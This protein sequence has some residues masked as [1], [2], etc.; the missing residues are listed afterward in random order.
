MTLPGTELK[1]Y[2]HQ[3]W[4]FS[5]SATLETKMMCDFKVVLSFF[6]FFPSQIYF[7]F[8]YSF[9]RV[10]FALC[11]FG[12][13]FLSNLY[14]LFSTA[15][16]FSSYVFRALFCVQTE[17]WVVVTQANK[18]VRQHWTPQ[19]VLTGKK[20][21]TQNTSSTTTRMLRPCFTES[22]GILTS[23]QVQ[24]FSL[25]VLYLAEQDVQLGWR[26]KV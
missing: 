10:V 8:K 25:S 4:G 14:L 11:L 20:N 26:N 12:F 18:L 7:S 19:T 17:Q 23:F 1:P 16:P 3:S 5:S 13:Y 24:K 15:F 21:T 9:P 22:R 6:F 2:L